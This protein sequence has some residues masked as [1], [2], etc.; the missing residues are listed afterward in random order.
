MA[1]P[2]LLVDQRHQAVD[3][4]QPEIAHPEIEGASEMQRLQVVTPGKR[5]IVI[6]P[7]P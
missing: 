6:A 2:E 1:E 5:N 7:R 3:L 4:A